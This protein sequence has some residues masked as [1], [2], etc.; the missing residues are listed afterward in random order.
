LLT[1]RAA[2]FCKHCTF[3]KREDRKQDPQD[4]G[5]WEK[6]HNIA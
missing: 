6:L 2:A 3:W 4:G 1:R 5:K